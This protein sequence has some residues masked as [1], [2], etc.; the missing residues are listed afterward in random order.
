MEAFQIIGWSMVAAVTAWRLAWHRA[1]GAID[2]IS[3]Q[4][5]IESRQ[6]KAEAMRWRAKAATLSQQND[7]WRAGHQEGRADVI[8]IV[9]LLVAARQ[10]SGACTCGTAAQVNSGR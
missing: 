2:H 5:A 9:P 10:D 4:A 8:S 1:R 6:W 7:A 3:A